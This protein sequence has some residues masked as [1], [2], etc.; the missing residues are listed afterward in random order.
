MRE[1]DDAIESRVAQRLADWR[2]GKGWS[3]DELAT[4]TGVSR[5]SGPTSLRS[6]RGQRRPKRQHSS[7]TAHSGISR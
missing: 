6:S 7:A 2:S 1:I 5:T 4:Q 3:L